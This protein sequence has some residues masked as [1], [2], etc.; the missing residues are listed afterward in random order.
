[1]LLHELG[2]AVADVEMDIV[3]AVALDLMVDR[4][5]HYVTRRKFGALVIVGH[6]AMAAF[7]MLQQPA[8]ASNRLGDQEVLDLQII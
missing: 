1:M 4:P 2:F 6:E 8:L 5:G 7:R 3:E